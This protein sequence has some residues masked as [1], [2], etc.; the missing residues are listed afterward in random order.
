VSKELGKEK[1][2]MFEGKPMEKKKYRVRVFI[3]YIVHAPS[4]AIAAQEAGDDL[5][6]GFRRNESF[7]FR[8]DVVEVE[9]PRPEKKKRWRFF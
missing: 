9:E 2:Y 5:R 8:T 4:E 1:D 7:V 6:E 3:E